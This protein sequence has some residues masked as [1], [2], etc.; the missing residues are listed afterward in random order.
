MRNGIVIPLLLFGALPL[1]AQ[2][3]NAVQILTQGA[4]TS[5]RGLSAL[6]DNVAWVS[7][8][9]GFVGRTT[10][11]G[12]HWDFTQVYPYDQAEF[13]DIEAFDE[14][15]AVVMSSTQ[16]AALLKTTDGGKT[17][18]T[19]YEENDP[20]VFL[21]GMD[22]RDDK[23]GVCFGDPVNGRFIILTTADGGSSW[24]RL[25]TSLCPE[26]KPGV[27][28]FAASG[29]SIQ[30]IGSTRVIFATGGN[31]AELYT[32]RE[33][34]KKWKVI[35]TPMPSGYAS[36]G[37][38]S[39][40]F[41]DARSGYI[42]GGDYSRDKTVT[43]NFFYTEDGGV[44]WQKPK[45]NPGGYRSCIDFADSHT[46]ICC[47]P[48]GVDIADTDMFQWTSLSIDKFN[49]VSASPKGKTVWLAG[50]NGMVGKLSR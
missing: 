45:T 44:S 31:A 30:C 20:D 32:T 47:G 14:N 24:N 38:F 26:A 41:T 25:D 50:E 12:A 10:D 36:S 48:S 16:P 28:G 15:T 7:G 5:L 4:Q 40:R 35:K 33:I 3:K 8:S 37:I 42:I 19:I 29:T 34:G 49:A 9:H 39:I 23:S 43:D 18:N 2:N 27:A 46:L 11:G 21:D 6:S 13:R 1:A 17:W 22:F